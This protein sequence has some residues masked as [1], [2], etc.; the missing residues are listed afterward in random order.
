MSKMKQFMSEYYSE[1]KK[2]S[3]FHGKVAENEDMP[4]LEQVMQSIKPNTNQQ[5]FAKM[6]RKKDTIRKDMRK[7]A[8]ARSIQTKSE[9]VSNN[10]VCQEGGVGA[11]AGT[12]SSQG[13]HKSDSKKS[14]FR[15]LKHLRNSL[16]LVN[17]LASPFTP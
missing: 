4:L 12:R 10:F 17:E 5:N 6:L 15:D 7:R 1:L 2:E 14:K 9:T 13:I 16:E 8:V 3:G 11:A